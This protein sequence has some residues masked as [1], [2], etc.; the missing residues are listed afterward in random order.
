M[1]PIMTSPTSNFVVELQRGEVADGIIPFSR[2]VSILVKRQ[3]FCNHKIKHPASQTSRGVQNVYDQQPEINGKKTHQR[4]VASTHQKKAP[5]KHK[6]ARAPAPIRIAAILGP[7]VT[8]GSDTG[9]GLAGILPAYSVGGGGGM[10]V[11]REATGTAAARGDITVA[12]GSM[13]TTSNTNTICSPKETTSPAFSTRGPANS[14]PFTNV[15]LVEP[16]SSSTYFPP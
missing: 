10:R 14:W 4:K 6:K 2:I 11:G 16:R 3:G 5:H 13:D 9:P 15:P 7:F 1:I 12:P 8:I